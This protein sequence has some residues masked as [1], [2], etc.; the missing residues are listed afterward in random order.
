MG[1]HQLNHAV[2]SVRDAE[3]SA[4]FYGEVLG[5]ARVPLAELPGAV[6]MRAPDSTNDHDLGLFS[7]GDSP[8]SSPSGSATVGLYH[9]AWEVETLN[10]LRMVS[11]NLQLAGR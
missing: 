4:D 5:F 9:L 10:D 8:R 7:V 6:F 3:R 1:I 11:E 2:L